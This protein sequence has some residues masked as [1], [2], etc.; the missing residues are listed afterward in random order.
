MNQELT[1]RIIK[2]LG[3]PAMDMIKGCYSFKNP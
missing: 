1:D 3:L 2:P